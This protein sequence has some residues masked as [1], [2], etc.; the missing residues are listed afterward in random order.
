M[1]GVGVQ[2]GNREG[3]RVILAG[4]FMQNR[5]H[6][7]GYKEIVGEKTLFGKFNRGDIREIDV[8]SSGGSNEESKRLHLKRIK[9]IH[10]HSLKFMNNYANERPIFILNNLLAK[11]ATERHP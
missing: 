5:L 2:M 4:E 3:G 10:I 8:M 11:I 6:G 7:E 1:N 9:S